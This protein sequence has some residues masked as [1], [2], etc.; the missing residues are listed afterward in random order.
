MFASIRIDY[1]VGQR[2]HGKH[3]PRVGS[4]TRIGFVCT[5]G[6]NR[7]E[8]GEAR[9]ICFKHIEDVANWRIVRAVSQEHDHLA[10]SQ[11]EEKT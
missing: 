6:I 5:E 11:I 7:L 3:V 2:R 8:I 9:A 4:L 10:A 1:A